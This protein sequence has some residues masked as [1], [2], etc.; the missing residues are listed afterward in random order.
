M[1]EII[2]VDSFD[3]VIFGGTGDL[4][5]RKIFPAFYHRELD[6]QLPVDAR[7]IGVARSEMSVDAFRSRVEASLR[8][9]VAPELIDADAISRFLNRVHYQRIDAHALEGY[10]GL[11]TRLADAPERTR[12]FYL[13]TAPQLFGAIAENLNAV[14]L[15]NGQQH[16]LVLEKPIGKDLAS[17]QQINDEVGQ[18]FDETQLYRIDHYLGKESVQNLLALRFSNIL[19][20][21][22]WSKSVI[23]H[24]QI[25]VSESVGLGDRA[26]YYDG[27]GAMRDMVQNHLLQLL[28][29]TA[30]EP[31]Q[32]LESDTL[33]DEKL[34]VLKAL[35]PMSATDVQNHSIRGQYVAGSIHGEA[36]P[37][38]SDELGRESDT[39]T[40]VALR[41]L[42]DNWRWAG[43]PFY[44]RTGKRM[45][46]RYS[47][48][49][50]QFR[51]VPHDVFSTAASGQ[52]GTP[53]EPNRLVIRLQP[54]EGVRMRLMTKEPGPGGM[55]LRSVPLDLAFADE[56]DQRFPDA[57]ERLLL[58]VVRGNRALFMRRDEVEA[59]WHWVEPIIEAWRESGENPRPY[60]AGTMG[61]AASSN[62]I[63][64]EERSWHEDMP[65]SVMRDMKGPSHVN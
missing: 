26:G 16:R 62:L 25:T 11:A 55:R 14:G 61:P 51:A 4:A 37:G 2:V 1:S 54:D 45:Q 21:T 65:S 50:I 53:P 46:Q 3:Y 6:G 13:A 33:R 15:A 48:I 9:F 5:Q 22:I 32:S 64:R 30:M 7:L 31:P 56:F 19:F 57:Y 38:Y 35:R 18:Y 52:R 63:D 39:E 20:E 40:F 36:V 23:D 49:V 60:Q 28:C 12:V 47:E 59:A 43:V 8:D 44:L 29:L 27:S 41:A 17:S 58:D 10:Q 42:I 24:V 34:K